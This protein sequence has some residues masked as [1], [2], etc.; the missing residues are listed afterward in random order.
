MLR[1]AKMGFN[2]EKLRY[3]PRPLARAITRLLQRSIQRPWIPIP[4]QRAWLGLAA[5]AQRRPR[6]VSLVRE[7]LGS[8]SG[9]RAE[10]ASADRDR[11]VLYLHGGGYIVGSDST[12]GPFAAW[13]AKVAGA[14][15]HALDYRLAPEHPYPAAVDDA[16]SAYRALVS[17]GMDPGGIVIAGDSAGAALAI[18]LVLRLREAGETMPAGLAL[19]NGGFDL[20]CS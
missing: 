16:A 17:S 1:G 20:H 7:T 10:T 6:D 18:A 14:P 11:A 13:I 4:L 5:R 9:I 8:R 12:H 3:L 19:I 2:A 15:V